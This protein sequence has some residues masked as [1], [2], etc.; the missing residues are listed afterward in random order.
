VAWK[1][2]VRLGGLASKLRKSV[3][4]PMLILQAHSTTPGFPHKSWVLNSVPPSCRASYITVSMETSPQPPTVPVWC[5]QPQTFFTVDNLSTMFSFPQILQYWLHF[6]TQ[7]F[8]LS[9]YTLVKNPDV[10][11]MGEVLRTFTVLKRTQALRAVV[12]HTSNPSTL[13]AEAGKSL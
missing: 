13:K 1:S 12:A 8:S 10:G 7:A 2:P 5:Y 11:E 6:C 3:S 4:S 9:S